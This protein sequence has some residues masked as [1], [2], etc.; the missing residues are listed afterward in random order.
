VAG[1]AKF[2][3]ELKQIVLNLGEYAAYVLWNSIGRE[4]NANGAV[5]LINGTKG[6]DTQTVLGNAATIAE[7]GCAVIPGAR[8]D[9][10]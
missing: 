5:G 1:N 6:V 10:A 4:H 3:A 7:A 9:L 2:T 8:I